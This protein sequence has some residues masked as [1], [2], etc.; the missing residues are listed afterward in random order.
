MGWS[1]G[2]SGSSSG[3]STASALS[4]YPCHRRHRGRGADGTLTACRR[5]NPSRTGRPCRFTRCTAS[6]YVSPSTDT[7]AT[8]CSIDPCVTPAR[9]DAPLKRPSCRSKVF[10]TARPLLRLSTTPSDSLCRSTT[11]S[12]KNGVDM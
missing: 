1:S 11:K 7:P 2:S 3:S 10:T 12:L 5:R 4:T 8:L 6:S 9:S